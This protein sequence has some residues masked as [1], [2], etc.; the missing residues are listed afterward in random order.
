MLVER[1]P[2]GYLALAGRVF[3]LLVIGAPVLWS[4]DHWAVASLVLLGAIMVACAGLD[5]VS[6]RFDQFSPAPEAVL[7]ATVCSLWV[8][9]QSPLVAALALPA[10][11]GGLRRGLRGVL[12]ALTAEMVVLTVITVPGWLPDVNPDEALATSTWLLAGLGLG[13]IGAFLH[14][15]VRREPSPSE[16]YVY[17]R[18][19]LRQLLDLSSGLDSGLDPQVLGGRILAEVRDELPT[20]TLA[21]YVAR[22]HTV[23]P[24]VTTSVGEPRD[25]EECGMVAVHAWSQSHTIVDGHVFAFPLTTGMDTPA[26]I[27]GVLSGRLDN[28]RF[29]LEERL[30][31]LSRRLE[32][33]ALHLD[34][35]LLFLAFRDAA[36]AEERRRLAREM[37]DGVAQDIASLGYLVDVLVAKPDA[38]EVPERIDVLRDRISSVVSEVRQTVTDLRTD[39]G[40]SASLGAAIS[41]LARSLS[42]VSGIPI[43]VTLDEHPARLRSDVEAELLRIAQ[44]AMNNA[45]KHARASTIDVRCQVHAPQALISVSDNG[46]GLQRG[47]TDSHGLK[48]MR[49]RAMLLN[50]DLYIEEVPT[51]GLRVS[52]WV[53]GAARHDDQTETDP[54]ETRTVTA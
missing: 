21:L 36:S 31:R 23:T 17:A 42:E 28:Q 14:S 49:E 48:I 22:E 54:S 52:V 47:R 2:L 19:L 10:L 44:E 1:H 46:L 29:G 27:A 45:V 38:P 53:P 12:V 50:A 24:L 30:R 8:P 15:V 26:V 5:H 40:T 32:P 37:H 43:R 33:S 4:K 7:V 25:L 34:T 16:P 39:V 35:A 41:A 11:S 51:G 6:S 9:A 3:G 20:S 13:L 18:S